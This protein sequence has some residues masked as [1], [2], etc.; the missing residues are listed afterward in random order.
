MLHPVDL[1]PLQV[2]ETEVDCVGVGPLPAARDAAFRAVV[3]QQLR[4]ILVERQLG[5]GPRPMLA[6]KAHVSITY[7]RTCRQALVRAQA[8]GDLATHVPDVGRVFAQYPTDLTRG[9]PGGRGRSNQLPLVC[10]QVPSHAVGEPDVAQELG[11]VYDRGTSGGDGTRDRE[12]V[13]ASQV[14]SADQGR[15]LAGRCRCVDPMVGSA[16]DGR[17]VVR[18]DPDERAAVRMSED[19]LQ[20]PQYSRPRQDPP[21]RGR[22]NLCVGPQLDGRGG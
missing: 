21:V 20:A 7:D 13:A 9:R 1:R 10:A 5:G 11:H 18:P 6:R 2:G 4:E 8:V 15:W 3:A 19:V 16:A 14:A 17:E 22:S 12:E